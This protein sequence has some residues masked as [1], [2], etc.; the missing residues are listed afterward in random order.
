MLTQENKKFKLTYLENLNERRCEMND[1]KIQ[2]L[3]AKSEQS[4]QAY[5]ALKAELT[6]QG[7]NSRQRYP[8]LKELKE[9]ANADHSAYQKFAVKEIKSELNKIIAADL[10]NRK[11]AERS[12]SAWK[13]AKHEAGVR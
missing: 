11:A 8:L 4:A 5:E 10:P 1:A 2:A 6:A 12:R 7:L 13:K 9:I 3:K